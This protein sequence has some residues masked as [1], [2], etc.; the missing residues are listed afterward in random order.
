MRGGY[1]RD[2]R[3]L[4]GLKTHN[5][6]VGLTIE[7]PLRARAA[8]ANLAGARVERHQLEA[9][10]RLQGQTIEEQVRN[11]AQAVETARLRVLSTLTGSENAALQLLGEQRLFEVGRSTTFLIFQ[12]ENQLI[13]ARTQELRAE[14]DYNKALAELQRST[15]TTLQANKVIILSPLAP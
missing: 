13:A 9:N 14:T 12:R 1:Y 15:F 4:A 3:N 10:M 11:A 5:I 6:V 7:I 2:L 8:K